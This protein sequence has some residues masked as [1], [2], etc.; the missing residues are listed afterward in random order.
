MQWIRTLLGARARG[1]WCGNQDA[2][3]DEEKRWDMETATK[4][5][6]KCAD[7]AEKGRLGD[8]RALLDAPLEF[9]EMAAVRRCCGFPC[10]KAQFRA[11]AD[12]AELA[13]AGCGGG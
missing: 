13:A 2:A 10:S 4:L 3:G 11:F 7:D 5:C 8:E 1:R 12:D 9:D 6:W